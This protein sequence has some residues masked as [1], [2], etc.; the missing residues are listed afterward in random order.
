MRARSRANL[1]VEP[2][3][4]P[5]PSHSP[6]A[7]PPGGGYRKRG[8]KRGSRKL[9]DALLLEAAVGLFDTDDG[10]SGIETFLASGPGQATFVGR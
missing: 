4:P 1:S 6:E 5:D 8:V 9:T 10:R 7:P 3:C 2:G